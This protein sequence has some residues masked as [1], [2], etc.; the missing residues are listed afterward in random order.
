[1]QKLPP[2]TLLCST[3][4]D[5]YEQDWQDVV[6]ALH[7]VVDAW[8]PQEY[9]NWLAA[10]ATSEFAKLNEACI[11]PTIVLT[12]DIGPNDPLAIVR[13]KLAQAKGPISVWEYS[14]AVANGAITKAVTALI[15][16]LEG[17]M[18]KVIN[19]SDVA[20]DFV[21]AP[22]NAWQCIIKG[23]EYVI[24][25]AMLD[26]YRRYGGDGLCGR[27]Y[28]GWPDSNEVAVPSIPGATVQRFQNAVLIFDP[29]HKYYPPPGAGAVYPIDLYT[30]D[31]GID[32]RIPVLQQQL[33][34]LQQQLT[35]CQQNNAPLQ[36]VQQIKTIVAPF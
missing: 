22:G 23:H 28:L 29:N 25:N 16:S 12:N 18:G 30:S 8:W 6:H 1:M 32:P 36:A 13:Q 19:L 2:G 3:W 27:T 17:D 20:T 21:Q 33:T 11:Q 5:P 15:A 4:A 9:D 7:P 14:P 10:A 35:N 34:T 26:E 24:G 31:L